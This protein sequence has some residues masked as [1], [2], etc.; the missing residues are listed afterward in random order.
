MNINDVREWFRLADNDFESAIFLHK[1]VRK[2]S[3]II[4][5]HCAQS[6][7][8]YLKG[9]LIYHNVMPPKTHDLVPLNNL[10]K[11]I[12][13]DFGNIQFECGIITRFS[14]DIRYPNQ[15][16]TNETDANLTIAAVEKIR[17]FK[18]ILDLRN[19]IS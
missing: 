10:C 14:N 15:Y 16:E 2:F 11:A 6:V 9:Y 17:N 8:K 19:L 7:E 13:G 1:A 4:C 5:Y 18:P 12:D 3:E